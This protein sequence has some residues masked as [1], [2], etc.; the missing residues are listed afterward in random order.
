[1]RFVFP[2]YTLCK[3]GAQRMLAE[4][5]NGLVSKGHDVTIIMAKNGVVDY[6]INAKFIRS[7]NAF[8]KESDFP[9]ADVIVSNFYL[10]IEAAEEASQNGKGKH[11]RLSMC[12]EPMFLKDQHL[13]F[14]TYNITK[15]LFVLSDYQQKI[16]ELSH[17]VKGKIIP[18]GV[19][20]SFRNLGIRQQ[21][22]SLTISAIVRMPEGGYAWQR[23][24]D[25]LIETLQHIKSGYPYVSI[26]LICP[27][28]E[29]KLSKKLK[30]IQ[31]TGMFN[32][33]LPE[34]D[35]QLNLLYNQTDIY[36][37]ASIFEAAPLPPLEAMK[38]GAALATY[39]SGGNVDYCKHETTAL[40]SYAYEKNLY[41]HI[42]RLILTPELRQKLSVQGELEANKWTWQNSTNQFEREI[43]QLFT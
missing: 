33:K 38:C 29:F 2:I 35:E 6:P 43:N 15:N 22:D 27:P 30:A 42:A 10:T 1:M 20:E 37:A 26:N 12:Y 24:Q 17:G 3:G 7:P 39:Y 28:D 21:N 32:F 19:S 25:E 16:I 41:T 18:V 5:T 11:V 13:T 31:S 36:V 14:P 34:D 4:I 40:M 9:Y 8:L 23:N